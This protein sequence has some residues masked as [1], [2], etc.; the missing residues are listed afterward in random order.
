MN[1]YL[2][3]TSNSNSEIVE[4]YAHYEEIIKEYENLKVIQTMKPHECDK[5]KHD[6]N[7]LLKCLNHTASTNRKCAMIYLTGKLYLD[8]EFM[9]H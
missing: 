9:L 4:R 2:S 1:F 6:A 7:V 5:N 3:V 8:A